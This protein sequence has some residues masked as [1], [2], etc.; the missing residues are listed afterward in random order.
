MSSPYAVHEQAAEAFLREALAN[1]APEALRYCATF[2]EAPLENEGETALFAFTLAPGATQAACAP[3]DALH[4]CA[5]GETTPNYFPAYGLEPDD[6]YS[7]HVGTRFMLE[8][9]IQRID[10][11]NEPPDARAMLRS[12]VRTHA[13]AAPLGIEE[14]AALF[15]C[16]DEYFAVYRLPIDGKDY[17][18]MGAD[19]PPGFYEMTQHPPQAALRLH[20]GKLIRREAQRD[21][22]AGV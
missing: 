17:Y 19:L 5:V 14:L 3:E 12:V 4:Y 9:E 11:A 1:R 20:L 18:V 6:A 15:R 21:R 13:P 2:H 7:F 22:N 10:N 16:G 8:M